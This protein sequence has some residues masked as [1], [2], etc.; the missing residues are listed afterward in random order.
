MKQITYNNFSVY[1][2]DCIDVMDDMVNNGITV[3]LTVTSPPYD[4]LRTYNNESTWDFETFKKVAQGLWDI[5]NDGGV[6]VWVVGDA[7]V[8]GS[9]T[10][11]SFKQA[12]YFMELGFKLHDTMIYE[13]NSSSF[14][15]RR[16]S[17]RYT[18]IFEYMF[19]FVK[20]KIHDCE[21]IADKENKWAGFTNWGN[22]TQYNK[23]GELIR[24]NNIKPVPRYSLRNNIWKYSVGFNTKKFGK[25]PAVFPL[26]LAIDHI[27]SWSKPE[28][29]I[30][31]PFL[32]SG[33]TMDAC[34]ETCRP[35]F[36]GSEISEEYFN[37]IEKKI[38]YYK[39]NE[40]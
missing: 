37:I 3:D 21:L 13:K 31:D 15:A 8:N 2:G 14:P 38:E 33:T 30:F 11:T 19:V 12:L 23:N 32:G 18:Q 25:H 26:Q 35:N 29:V 4:Q 34:V 39:G 22:N 6:V 5:T 9:E 27:L 28:H 16:G 17:K 1:N 10:G 7:C 24:T 40:K 36:I 20:G